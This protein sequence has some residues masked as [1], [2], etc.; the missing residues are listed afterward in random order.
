VKKCFQII[1]LKLPEQ[2]QLDKVG[3]NI[4]RYKAASI[5]MNN[6][7]DSVA[8]SFAT[9]HKRM[10]YTYMNIISYIIILLYVGY[11]EPDTSL[12]MAAGLGI[13]KAISSKQDHSRFAGEVMDDDTV[14][15]DNYENDSGQVQSS[16][17]CSSKNSKRESTN[18]I[19]KMEA[20]NNAKKRKTLDMSDGKKIIIMNFTF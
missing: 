16:K 6:N 8:T 7:V 2:F 3:K 20:V 11:I 18:E 19:D 1:N 14:T 17:S 4:G 9:K 15:E 10:I 12:L 13:A 5:C